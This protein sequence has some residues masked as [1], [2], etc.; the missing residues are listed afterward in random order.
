MLRLIRN[1]NAR[2]LDCGYFYDGTYRQWLSE[3]SSNGRKN[4]FEDA[5]IIYMRNKINL[6]QRLGGEYIISPKPGL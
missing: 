4:P 6:N 3:S 5:N 2:W 1:Y